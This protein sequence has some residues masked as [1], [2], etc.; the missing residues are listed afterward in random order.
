MQEKKADFTIFGEM[1]ELM[2]DPDYLRWIADKLEHT[3]EP[4]TI[5][6]GIGETMVIS[7]YL[8]DDERTEMEA[9]QN[10]I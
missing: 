8:T 5:T 9:E 7:V 1:I 4:E 10:E 6:S 2:I 3:A